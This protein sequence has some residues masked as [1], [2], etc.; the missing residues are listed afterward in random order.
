MLALAPLT[1]VHL[2]PPKLHSEL[3]DKKLHSELLHKKPLI[4][5]LHTSIPSKSLMHPAK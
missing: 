3:V 1:L 4:A 2:L 5:Q